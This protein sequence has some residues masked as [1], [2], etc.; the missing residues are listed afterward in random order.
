M[1]WLQARVK[2]LASAI[3]DAV[4]SAGL[5]VAEWGPVQQFLL[6][7]SKGPVIPQERITLENIVADRLGLKGINKKMA[8]ITTIDL[9]TLA[10]SLPYA[11]QSIASYAKNVE[12]ITIQSFDS[13]FSTVLGSN[14]SWR[15]LANESYQ[16]FHEAGVYIQDTNS[17]YISSNWA[18]DFANPINVSILNLGDYSLTSERYDGLFAPNGGTTYV[19]PGTNE[20]PQLLFCE[21]G[22]FEVASGLALVDVKGKTTKVCCDI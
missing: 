3:G 1:D 16:A 15:L 6:S 7:L 19:T 5:R 18:N 10:T 22:S 17:L 2:P 12:N 20:K 14:P 4:N 11:N 21:E 9:L 13:S 8:S